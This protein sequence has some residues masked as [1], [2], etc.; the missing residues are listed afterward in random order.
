MVYTSNR[1]SHSKGS[2]GNSEIKGIC[3]PDV[4][5][6]AWKTIDSRQELDGRNE[7][8]HSWEVNVCR[9]VAIFATSFI[10]HSI[11]PLRVSLT[12][13][14][15]SSHI[16]TDIYCRIL[17]ACQ[18]L[19]DAETYFFNDCSTIRRSGPPSFPPF[20]YRRYKRESRV[21]RLDDIPIY[22][23][24]DIFTLLIHIVSRTKRTFLYLYWSIEEIRYC[25]AR[26]D[27]FDYG[28]NKLSLE[29]LRL[30]LTDDLIYCEK[31]PVW[32]T[33]RRSRARDS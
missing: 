5:D 1:D 13:F 20:P 12:R 29:S 18:C 25:T 26:R 6:R 7:G 9:V 15:L 10:F 23:I 28:Y 14:R 19:D 4:S 21:Y 2:L 17:C 3:F 30:L 16:R 8:S 31:T 22:I 27:S 32:E 33:A 24:C 11:P